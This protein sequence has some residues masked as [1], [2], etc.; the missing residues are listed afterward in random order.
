MCVSNSGWKAISQ[1]L[2][3]ILH[4]FAM[5]SKYTMTVLLMHTAADHVDHFFLELGIKLLGIPLYSSL[6][7]IPY[8]CTSVNPSLQVPTD[9][10]ASAF[11]TRFQLW[12]TLP[13]WMLSGWMR[14]RFWWVAG[15]H[16]AVTCLPFWRFQLFFLAGSG[17]QQP[18]YCSFARK[19]R[20]SGWLPL[21]VSS[22]FVLGGE[23][24]DSLDSSWGV[25]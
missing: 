18:G 6:L 7:V 11:S 16:F 4:I 19:W 10:E 13:F 2:G 5:Y 9:T 15:C 25:L 22:K 21:P 12:S 17:S 24:A 3:R 20:E 8:I 1:I 23:R 14:G